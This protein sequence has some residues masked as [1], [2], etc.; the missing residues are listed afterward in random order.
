MVTHRIDTA[1]RLYCPSCF[2][3]ARWQAGCESVRRKP[4]GDGNVTPLCL[5]ENHQDKQKGAVKLFCSFPQTPS[6]GGVSTI[7]AHSVRFWLPWGKYWPTLS[8]YLDHNPLRDV[9][10][11]RGQ[12]L[13]GED[14]DKWWPGGY[15]LRG[16]KILCLPKVL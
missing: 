3:G 1:H 12:G 2:H 16:G 13:E 11:P 8:G 4:K 10:R 7:W 5:H 14:A 15:P 9:E 6:G